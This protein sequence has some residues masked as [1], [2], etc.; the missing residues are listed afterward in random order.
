MAFVRVDPGD[1]EYGQ[2][3]RDRPA[4]ERLFRIEVEDI[5]LVDPGRHDQQ[6]AL[7]DVRRR[8]RILNELHQLIAKYNLAGR[9]GHVDAELEFRGIGLADAQGGRAPA[10]MSSANMCRPRTR[11][12]PLSAIVVRSNSGLVDDEI[13]RRERAGYLLQIK[14]GLVAGVRIEVVRTFDEILRPSGR[15]DISL[16]YKIEIGIGLPIRVGK[17]FVAGIERGDRRRRLA[18]EAIEGRGPEI[19]ELLGEGRLRVIARCGSA[20]NIRRRVRAC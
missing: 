13:R 6:R 15:E 2:P 18:V 8:G 16:L 5:E 3:L 7:V 11:L 14:R 12:S 4:D 9:R 10:S 1:D 19:D 17:A 20:R